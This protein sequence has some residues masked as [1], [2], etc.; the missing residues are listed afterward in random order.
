[1][2]TSYAL[3][4]CPYPSPLPD[5]HQ[6]ACTTVIAFTTDAAGKANVNFQFP[7]NGI[8]AGIFAA[9]RNDTAEF[10]SGFNVPGSGQEYRSSLKQA[11]SINSGTGGI[12]PGGDGLTGC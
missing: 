9:V 6:N 1:M 8:W 10:V 12:T 3:Q 5:A 4:Y 2:S 7:K 11:S